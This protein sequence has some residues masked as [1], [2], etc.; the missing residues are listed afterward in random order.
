MT[1]IA[2]LLGNGSARDIGKAIAD[3]IITSCAA[4][5][6]YLDRI[7]SLNGEVNCVRSISPQALEDAWCADQELL[8][9][10]SRGPLHGVP[11][12]VKDNIFTADGSYCSGGSKA[13]EKFIPPY[14]ATLI[15]RLHEAGAVLLGKTHLTE[16]A[17]FVSDT[18]PAEFSGVA[19]V[20]RNPLGGRYDRGQGSSIGSAAALAA[21]FCAFAIGSETQNSLQTPA[22]FTSVVGFKPS[23]G[24]VSRHGIIPLV[25]SQ[26]SPGP[27][28][29]T[30]DD[31][32]LVYAAIH[33]ADINDRATQTSFPNLPGKARTLPGI[34]IGV[35]RS[36]DSV[37]GLTDRQNQ[38]YE[39]TL[40]RLAHAGAVM[41]DPCHFPAQAEMNRLQSC[42]FRTEFRASLNAMLT[43]LQPCGIRSLEEII[44]WNS[45]H[46]EAIPYGQS[47]L[48]AANSAPDMASR[49]YAED[50]KKD[51]ALSLEEG[52]LAALAS[53]KA[54]VLLSPMASAARWT[55]KSGVPVIAI[56]CGQ[57][58][59]GQPFGVTVYSAPGHDQ[60]VL[61]VAE[62]IEK[63]VGT[64]LISPLL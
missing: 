40:A 1:D 36:P 27:L 6:W 23:V 37:T 11:Y 18:M 21:G 50:R 43:A 30:V 9:G 28:T 58:Q 25:P 8:A 64:R 22:I 57:D 14:E 46:P 20:V 34:R 61:Q 13:L 45:A 44:A 41:I 60:V 16:F 7:E 4:T 42:V 33:G 55:G 38:M 19:G 31:A 47:L 56:P 54:E 32:A 26:D 49:H 62:A 10:Y 3:G 35:Q 12:L 5:H 39:H 29:R 15:A 59:D 63:A 51:I 2:S 17:D 48:I 52:I 24:R 53:A